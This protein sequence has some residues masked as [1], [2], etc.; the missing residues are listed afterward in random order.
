[1]TDELQSTERSRIRQ[2]I[3]DTVK[4]PT[5]GQVQEVF[6]HTGTEAR[7]SNH[8]VSVSVPPGPNPAETYQRRP[9]M[10]STSGVVSTP[11][12]DDLVLLL[13]P[14]RSDEPFVIGTLY[15][16]QDDDRAPIGGATD[17][18][19]SRTGASIEVVTT[20]SDETVI[21]LVDRDADDD[22]RSIGLEVNVASGDIVVK[23]QN[24]HGIEI[25]ANGD[26]KIYGDSIDFDTN[27]DAS[28]NS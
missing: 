7:P 23:N 18:R 26:V 25:P 15:G 6:P 19:I 28:F 8:E 12:V 13:F 5:V 3:Q 2:L 22:V 16:D 24:G 4:Q 21:R 11:Q 9:V 20:D 14:S 10:V 27:G 17:Y 1:M